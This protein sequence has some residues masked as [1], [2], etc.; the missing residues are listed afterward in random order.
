MLSMM[1]S[2]QVGES[3][4]RFGIAAECTDVL[5]ASIHTDAPDVSQLLSLLP[6]MFFSPLC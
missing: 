5:V 4:K 6:C 3:L 1:E 2:M